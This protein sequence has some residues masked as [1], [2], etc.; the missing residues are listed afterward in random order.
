M[1]SLEEFYSTLWKLL[2]VAGGVYFAFDLFIR[3]TPVEVGRETTYLVEPLDEDGLPNYTLALH[4]K[5]R[6]DVTPEDN[7]AALMWQ[8]V[9]PSEVTDEEYALICRELAVTPSANEQLVTDFS[10]DETIARLIEWRL[11]AD[12]AGAE[13]ELDELEQ[14]EFTEAIVEWVRPLPGLPWKREHA[15]PLANWLDENQ[16]QLDRLVTVAARPKFYSPSPNALADS[17]TAVLDMEVPHILAVRKVSRT[18]AVRAAL[19]MGGEQHEKAWQDCLACWRLGECISNGPML[20][21]RLAGIG[22]R[23]VAMRST[24]ALVQVTDLPIEKLRQMLVEIDNLQ[25]QVDLAPAVDFSERLYFLDATLRL[26]THR[27]GGADESFSFSLPVEVDS[28]VVLR[29]GNEWFDRFVAAAALADPTRRR[30]EME[31]IEGELRDQFDA[32]LRKPLALA[33]N[34]TTRSE[35]VGSILTRLLMPN[36]SLLYRAQVR[37]ATNYQL[38]RLA[39]CLAIH[40]ATDGEYPKTLESLAPRVTANML[41]DPFSGEQLIYKRCEEGYLLYSVSANGLDEGG[42][43]YETPIVDGEWLSPEAW[44]EF[45]PPDFLDADIVIRVPLPPPPPLKLPTKPASDYAE[46]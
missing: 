23:D 19:R 27:L 7:A 38:T 41:I 40:H 35:F 1:K 33:F 46:P 16:T 20:L 14:V 11:A 24:V 3:R 22:I 2:I 31:A 4:Q 26:A 13:R 32:A 5:Q 6:E 34:R 29:V 9:R 36:A 42:D 45:S 8:V 17:N 44:S 37:D 18:L 39:V 30:A 21:D 12:D 28:N 25:Q 43:D 10:G 15:P